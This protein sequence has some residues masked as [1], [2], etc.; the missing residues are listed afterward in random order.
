M[1]S[2]TT[3]TGWTD[4]VIGYGWSGANKGGLNPWVHRDNRFID[5]DSILLLPENNAIHSLG[6]R[7]A[8]CLGLNRKKAVDISLNRN[9]EGG[10]EYF[11]IDSEPKT[12][13][14][15]AGGGFSGSLVISKNDGQ[16]QWLGVFSGDKANAIALHLTSV[17]AMEANKSRISRKNLAPNLQ[18]NLDF[19]FW[20]EI[21]RENANQENISEMDL[22][23]II[24]RGV[25]Y[26]KPLSRFKI[27]LDNWW[28][29]GC[30]AIK[31]VPE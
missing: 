21:P 4:F 22:S 14:A 9:R 13:I 23:S 10:T 3:P 15:C 2:G 25:F 31:D 5:N 18:H 1:R 11:R 28:C 20:R 12:N 27:G 29:G 8:Q 17:A 24:I 26:N 30:A 7:V 16:I 19:L 6:K